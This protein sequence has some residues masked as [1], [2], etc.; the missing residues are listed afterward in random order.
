MINI[1]SIPEINFPIIIEPIEYN[2]RFIYQEHFTLREIL[3]DYPIDN[4]FFYDDSQLK[5]LIE[6]VPLET[7]FIKNDSQSS[8]LLSYINESQYIFDIDKRELYVK[9]KNNS[10]YFL[11]ISEYRV[12]RSLPNNE[13]VFLYQWTDNNFNIDINGSP[14]GERISI[15][16]IPNEENSFFLHIINSENLGYTFTFLTNDVKK[17]ESLFLNYMGDDSSI[18][19]EKDK[20]KF[21]FNSYIDEEHENKCI[22]IEEGL[23]KTSIIL[24]NETNEIIIDDKRVDFNIFFEDSLSELLFDIKID[25]KFIPLLKIDIS[26]F[27]FILNE[28]LKQKIS[29][30]D[31][32]QYNFNDFRFI[33]NES[34]SCFFDQKKL[35]NIN[36]LK[37]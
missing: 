25:K 24:N 5:N 36:K 6:K 27:R 34:I 37:M 19:L 26:D 10:I 28:S 2:K 13:K 30:Q 11:S 12:E 9:E 7:V 29:L 4:K 35:T 14:D 33:V 16:S 8:M 18:V 3:E 17:D 15:A 31:I 23:K 22:S 20:I 1:D 21:T 32:K